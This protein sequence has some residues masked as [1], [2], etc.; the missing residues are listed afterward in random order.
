VDNGWVEITNFWAREK[1]K[2]KYSPEFWRARKQIRERNSNKCPPTIQSYLQ[3]AWLGTCYKVIYSAKTR[4]Y[5]ELGTGI[6]LDGTFLLL[7]AF[8]KLHLRGYRETAW[9][10]EN[11]ERPC[12][13]GHYGTA[14]CYAVGDPIVCLVEPRASKGWYT[15]MWST[16]QIV[17]T[18]I[19]MKQAWK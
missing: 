19:D 8:M 4:R 3:M 10:F 16:H 13:A 5:P 6:L 9:H 1:R 12:E 7:W 15:W 14:H 18:E 2:R 11:I 17:L